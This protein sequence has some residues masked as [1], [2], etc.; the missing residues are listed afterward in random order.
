MCT[1]LAI[2]A[3]KTIFRRDLRGETIFFSHHFKVDEKK[4]TEGCYKIS[5]LAEAGLGKRTAWIW[6]IEWN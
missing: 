1:D 3:T 4:E 5:V 6:K 2:I